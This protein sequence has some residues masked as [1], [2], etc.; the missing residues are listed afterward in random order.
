MSRVR[1]P[2]PAHKQKPSRDRDGFFVFSETLSQ[3]IPSS[4]DLAGDLSRERYALSSLLEF[5]RTLRPDLGPHGILR[6]V[7]RTIM[8]KALIMSSFVYLADGE[9]GDQDTFSLVNVA[10]FRSTK[11]PAKASLLEVHGLLATTNSG[12]GLSVGSPEDDTVIAFFGFAKPLKPGNTIEQETIFLQSLSVLTGIA[13]T[14]ARLFESEKERERLESEL[15]LARDIQSSLFPSKLPEIDGLRFAVHND[16]SELVGGDY[17]DVIGLSESRV[18]IAIADV[19]G[20]GV[21]AAITMSNVQAA[22]RTLASLL[23]NGSLTLIEVVQEINR[24]VFE[25]TP[26]ERFVT[27]VFAL[28]DTKSRDAEFIVCGHPLPI[29]ISN[30]IEEIPSS[31]MPL[32]IDPSALFDVQH[33]HFSE[34]LRILLYTDGLTEAKDKSGRELGPEGLRKK[35]KEMSAFKLQESEIVDSLVQTTSVSFA[36]DITLVAVRVV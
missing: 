9:G 3:P 36:D 26:A 13:L 15:R 27:A 4:Q 31:G 8:G 6:S 10:G 28:L 32:G 7:Q 21:S 25:S 1:I 18:L 12:F 14:N 19:V 11:F 23:R 16:A 24:L 5:A 33:V 20:K 22:L 35:L 29:L 34:E 17:Y 30:K 2:S